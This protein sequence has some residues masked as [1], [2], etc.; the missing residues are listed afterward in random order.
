MENKKLFTITC[1]VIMWNNGGLAEDEQET[2]SN[3]FFLTREE[4]IEHLKSQADYVFDMEHLNELED[5]EAPTDREVTVFVNDRLYD[6]IKGF[7]CTIRLDGSKEKNHPFIVE[8]DIVEAYDVPY[9]YVCKVTLTLS[10]C[11]CAAIKDLRL[12]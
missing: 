10:E 12:G 7:E 1:F 11:L 2:S 5:F 4:A 3:K 8:G 9:T 6:A